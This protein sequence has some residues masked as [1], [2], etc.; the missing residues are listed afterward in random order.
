MS[1]TQ[2]VSILAACKNF[3]NNVVSA[4]PE[5][6]LESLWLIWAL[7]CFKNQPVRES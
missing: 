1:S 7:F 3:K 6:E 4:P 5:T 2:F